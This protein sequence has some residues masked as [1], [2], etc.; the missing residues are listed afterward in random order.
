MA[1]IRDVTVV[2]I[3]GG[4]KDVFAALRSVDVGV[5]VIIALVPNGEL[6]AQ[7]RALG[8][9]IVECEYG[10]YSVSCNRGLAAVST[11][12]AFLIDSD[13]VIAPGCL[14]RVASA[15]DAH[16]VVRCHVE[17]GVTPGS[18]WG[19]IIARERDRTNNG[20]PIEYTP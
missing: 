12:R 6:A 1:Q 10:N 2:I 19:R 13:C 16:P 5:P 18:R 3:C 20:A 7:L 17:Y 4:G 9:T 11:R 8:A 15:L 14:E